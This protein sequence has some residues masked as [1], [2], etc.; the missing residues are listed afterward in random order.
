MNLYILLFII[1]WSDKLNI[2]H[3]I[4]LQFASF[5]H[6]RTSSGVELTVIRGTVGQYGYNHGH[7]SCHNTDFLGDFYAMMR[8]CALY[9]RMVYSPSIRA[10]VIET[11]KSSKWHTL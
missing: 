7:K 5:P 9:C 6:T 8:H 10:S 4:F 3:F 2:C 1:I 11:K